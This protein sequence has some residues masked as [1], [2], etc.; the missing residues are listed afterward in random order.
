M[1]LYLSE[2]TLISRSAVR[3]VSRVPSPLSNSLVGKAEQMIVER[4]GIKMKRPMSMNFRIP[5]SSA[6]ILPP[7]HATH[8]PRT[9]M[10]I[11]QAPITTRVEITS[12][13]EKSEPSMLQ[14]MW[15]ISKRSMARTS[16]ARM[17]LK[18]GS[19]YSLPPCTA[20]TVLRLITICVLTNSILP[21]LLRISRLTECFLYHASIDFRFLATCSTNTATTITRSIAAALNSCSP[22]SVH[23]LVRELR[24][25]FG[26]HREHSAPS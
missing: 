8:A 17:M 22:Q 25:Y 11:R 12:L 16:T 1:N 10:A 23:R 18:N 7:H 21:W 13:C 15:N 6:T 2:S 19:G 4:V 5:L 3:K 24:K 14:P 20:C 26:E 9:A